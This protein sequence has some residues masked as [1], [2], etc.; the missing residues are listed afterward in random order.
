MIRTWTSSTV[1]ASPQFSAMYVFGDSL[2]D[3]GNNNY[4]ASLAKANYLPYGIDFVEGPTGR[5]CNGKTI[6]DFLGELVGLP[7]IPA[8]ISTLSDEGSIRHG[9]NYASAAGGIR[10]DSGR[11]LGDRFSLY[12]QV[13]HFQRTLNQ[14]KNQMGDE[15][16]RRHLAKS[17][18]VMNLGNNDYL[19][20][21]LLPSFYN[22]SSIYKPLEYA[23]ILISTYTTRIMDLHKLGMRKFVIAAVGPLGCMPNQLAAGEAAPGTCVKVV[24]EIVGLFN[25]RLRTLIDRLNNMRLTRDTIFVYGNAYDVFYDIFHNSN[26]YGLAIVDRGCCGSGRYQGEITCLPL[27]IPCVDRDE[28]MFW[29]AY[30]PTELVNKIFAER[31]YAGSP[32]DCYPINVKKMA[33]L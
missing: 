23:E 15:E 2:V 27:Q 30:H 28:Y 3:H 1:D 6:I 25:V 29:D 17:L 9:V 19:N 16:I 31:A 14:M 24:N 8:F 21:Y 33:R 12:Q 11:Q 22:T 13:Q 20:N 26:K 32:A 18:V 7:I 4:L 10:D 5:F